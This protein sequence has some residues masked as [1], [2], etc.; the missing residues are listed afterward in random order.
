M[1]CLSLPLFFFICSPSNDFNAGEL[2]LG[3]KNVDL[4]TLKLGFSWR[5]HGKNVGIV[6]EA[7]DYEVEHA[8]LDNERIELMR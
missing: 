1:L 7:V 5:K 4:G 8:C 2:I 6:S 3:L